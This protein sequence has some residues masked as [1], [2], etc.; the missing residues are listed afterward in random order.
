MNDLRPN[1]EIATGVHWIKDLFVNAY[2]IERGDELVLIDSGMNSKAKRILR[3]LKNELESQKISKILLTHHHI[4]HVGGLHYLNELLKP[5]IYTSI[6]DKPIITGEKSRPLPRSVFLK[7][8]FYV[9]KPFMRA[10]PVTQVELVEDGEQMD[11]F[12]VY[13]LPGHTMGSLGFLKDNILFAGDA[14]VTS[15][16]SVKLGPKIVAES[17]EEAERSL[18]RMATLNFDMILSGHGNP[19]LEDA[20]NRVKDAVELL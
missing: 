15:K 5:T 20:S 17:L 10:K 12:I 11:D 8:L 6:E 18:R 4:D 7:P 3:Y 14:G 13:H 19:I 2:I 16:G 1:S 9:L